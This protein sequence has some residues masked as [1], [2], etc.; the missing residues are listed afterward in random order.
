MLITLA[1][2]IWVLCAIEV[3]MRDTERLMNMSIPKMFL[4]M[5][6]VALFSPLVLVYDLIKYGW[7]NNK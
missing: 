1:F 7:Y 6:C 5:M 4:W 3:S 2:I